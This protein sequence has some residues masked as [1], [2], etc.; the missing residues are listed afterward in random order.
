MKGLSVKQLDSD[1]DIQAILDEVE[2]AEKK[3]IQA[4]LDDLQADGR[5]IQAILDDLPADGRRIQAMLDSI[6][7]EQQLN[8]E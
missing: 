5:R 8:N 4:M 7:A 6:M 1:I 3:H 2:Q